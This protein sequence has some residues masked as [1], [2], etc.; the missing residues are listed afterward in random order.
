MWVC[1][2]ETCDWRTVEKHALNKI[3]VLMS[4]TPRATPVVPFPNPKSAACDAMPGNQLRAPILVVAAGI[5]ME[6]EM[7]NLVI[8]RDTNSNIVLADP[9]VSRRH[10]RLSVDVEGRVIL[11]D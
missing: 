2:R 3:E 10:A 1:P 9:L 7:G 5:E 4:T 8:G 6:H 11:E